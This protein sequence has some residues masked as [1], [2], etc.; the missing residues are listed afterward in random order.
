M[1][2]GDFTTNAIGCAENQPGARNAKCLQKDEKWIAIDYLLTKHVLLGCALRLLLLTLQ[3][4]IELLLA[5]HSLQMKA[6][7]IGISTGDAK[8]QCTREVK[9]EPLP[10]FSGDGCDG[11]CDVE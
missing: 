11:H 8:A 7:P 4:E 10:E 9:P 5:L 3:L 2:I 1:G 6:I